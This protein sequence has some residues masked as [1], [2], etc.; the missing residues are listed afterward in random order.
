L[1]ESPRTLELTDPRALK[2]LAHPVR[3]KLV[4]ALRREGPLTA[5]RAGKVIGETATTCSFHLRQLARYGL[6]E[7]AGGGRGRERPWR[8]TASF[9][10]WPSVARDP[11]LAA[12]TG[13]LG[14]VVADRYFER[15]LRWLERRADDPPEWQEAAQFGD[16]ILYLTA[17][18]LADLGRRLDELLRPF[19]ERARPEHA[20]LVA[21]IRLAFP[22]E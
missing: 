11:E 2:A 13:L 10:S 16:T 4:G 18:E 3:L 15:V 22:D 19:E 20:R 9:T 14:A 12:A 8:A 21:F 7:E 6:V 1:S 17:D 5:T